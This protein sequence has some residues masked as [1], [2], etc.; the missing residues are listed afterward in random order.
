MGIS[1][2][3]NLNGISWVGVGA[4][5]HQEERTALHRTPGAPETQYGAVLYTL[6]QQFITSRTIL[7]PVTDTIRYQ[8]LQIKTSNKTLCSFIENEN[9]FLHKH[10]Q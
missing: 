6:Q 2:R 7:T 5:Q 10:I 4:V 8:T 1:A 3:A 9:V